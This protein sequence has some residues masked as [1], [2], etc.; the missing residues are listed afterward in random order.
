[1]HKYLIGGSLLMVASRQ[2]GDRF[3]PFGSLF[4]GGPGSREALERV[5]HV[6]AVRSEWLEIS[7]SHSAF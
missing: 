7:A 5:K 3:G 4:R 1:M 2:N 6:S